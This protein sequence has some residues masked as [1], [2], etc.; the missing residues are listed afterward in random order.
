MKFLRTH[1]YDIGGIV[2]ILAAVALIGLWKQMASV[3]SEFCSDT[4]SSV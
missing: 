3:V 4:A 2:A 1:R